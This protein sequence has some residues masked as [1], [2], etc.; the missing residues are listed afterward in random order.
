MSHPAHP[1]L[2]LSPDTRLSAAGR[3]LTGEGLAVFL[4]TALVG[5][6][7]GVLLTIFGP[8]EGGW[9]G[10]FVRDFQLWC[11][12]GD[13]RSG[14]ISW[15]AVTA[16]MFEPAF[17]VGVA[18][19]LWR[20]QFSHL[21][22]RAVWRSHRAAAGA[23]VLLVAGGAG[24]LV[25]YARAEAARALILPPFP[26]ES[27]RVRLALPD[28]PLVDQKGAAFRFADLRGRVVLVTGVYA[29]C[30]TACPAIFLELKKILGELPAAERADLSIVALSLN[31]EYETTDL[32]DA[33]ATTRGLTYPEFRYVNGRDPAALHG[34]LTDLQFS[35]VRDPQTGIID[36]ANLFILVDRT[37][38]IAYRFSLDP[39]QR[40]WLRA[41]LRALLQE[42]DVL[43]PRTS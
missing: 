7:A 23:A 19:L 6:E 28:L 2:P 15:L 39:R 9:L 38:H 14:G 22:R 37:N 25:F 26:G 34:L 1:A 20:R 8:T 41:G 16:M 42:S 5:Y 33:V 12:R 18:A 13:P 36:H 21:G 4:L 32:M 43:P 17:V 35:A 11:Y 29:A 10:D 27:I 24:G 40:A 30:T 31:P 3:F